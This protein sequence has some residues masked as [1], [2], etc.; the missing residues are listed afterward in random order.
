MP[1]AHFAREHGLEMR[2]IEFMPLDAD[3]GWDNEQVLTG[4]EIRRV[5]E[6][7]I[8]PL[9]PVERSR[10]QPAGDRLPLCRSPTGAARSA[11]STP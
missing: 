7:A 3:G 2:F 6:E 9:A 5:L 1:L 10:P 4:D 11:S 8:G